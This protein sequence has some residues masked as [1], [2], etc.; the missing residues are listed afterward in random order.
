MSSRQRTSRKINPK[1]YCAAAEIQI[2]SANNAS[3]RHEPNPYQKS[4]R[5]EDG[6]RQLRQDA[7]ERAAR[8]RASATRSRNSLAPAALESVQTVRRSPL[9]S[10]I[11]TIR[12]KPGRVAVASRNGF[13]QSSPKAQSWPISPSEIGFRT[14]RPKFRSL[15]ANA[16][17]MALGMCAFR[18]RS[19]AAIYFSAPLEV[20]PPRLEAP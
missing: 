13:R 19:P 10:A 2:E 9:N 8:P 11:R 5:K 3:F 12:T 18:A 4:A 6:D 16:K 1:A 17:L 14:G 15:A 20:N 7:P